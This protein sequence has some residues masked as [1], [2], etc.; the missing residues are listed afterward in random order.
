MSQL[1]TT[2]Y[3]KI[4]F[5][6]QPEVPYSVIK[7]LISD[8]RRDIS[9]RVNNGEKWLLKVMSAM[10][11]KYGNGNITWLMFNRFKDGTY[12]EK[13]KGYRRTTGDRYGTRIGQRIEEIM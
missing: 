5:T 4:T 1:A 11:K 13:D 7:Y 9:D 6:V 8:I 10:K 3:P 12:W 2:K